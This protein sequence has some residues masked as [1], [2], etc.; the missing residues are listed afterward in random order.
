MQQRTFWLVA[1]RRGRMNL[2]DTKSMTLMDE[3][4]CSGVDGIWV[5][6]VVVRESG[7]CVG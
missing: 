3:V 4:G 6:G 7:R 5:S 2:Y 1:R